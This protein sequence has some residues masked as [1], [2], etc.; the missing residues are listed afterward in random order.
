MIL[1]TITKKLTNEER[2]RRLREK[3]CLYCGG[4]G[5][6]VTNCPNSKRKTIAATTPADTQQQG[7]GNAQA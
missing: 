7:K 5:H 2:A 3:L 4:Q 1:D 6:T